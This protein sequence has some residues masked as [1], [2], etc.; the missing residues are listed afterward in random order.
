MNN[1]I[2]RAIPHSVEAE[3]SVLGALMIENDAI[4]R[5]GGLQAEHFYRADHRSIFAEIM[6]LI[7]AGKGADVLTVLERLQSKGIAGDVGGLKYLNDLAQNTPSA[8][9]ISRYAD[10]V[11]DRAQKRGVAALGHEMQ[12]WVGTTPDS[13]AVLIDR[14]SAKLEKLSEAVVKSEPIKAAQGLADFLVHFEAADTDLKAVSTGLTDLDEKLGGGFVGGDLVVLAARPSMG[15]TAISLAIAANEAIDGNV[16]FLSLEMPN[17]QLQRRLAAAQGRISMKSLRRQSDMHDEDWVRITTAAQKINALEL[18]IDYQ[19][20]MSLLDVRSKARAHKR[21]HG[22]SLLCVDYLGLMRLGDEERNDLKIGAITR[23]LK[24]LALDLD[25][26][27]IL[28]SQLN[29]GVEQR[30]NKRPMM[31]DL[32]DSGSIEADADTIL[33]LY[34]DEV[35]NPDSPEKGICEVI[36]A[37]QRQGETGAVRVAFI[38]EQQRFEDLAYGATYAV[39]TAPKRQ[40]ESFN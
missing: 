19:T 28:L 36:I 38:G 21:K 1:D 39:K 33:F 8:A 20:D 30:P 16:L 40:T 22:L 24:N 6:K 23:G 10:I 7:A 27:V 17:V 26:P 2:Q 9:N 29:R 25:V 34:R 11:Q 31:S 14:A 3:Q 4:D 37:K 32:K 13:A 18:H 12:D 35:Y 15:K 5:I